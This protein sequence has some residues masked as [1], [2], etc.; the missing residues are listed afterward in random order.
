MHSGRR[1]QRSFYSSHFYTVFGIIGRA[2]DREALVVLDVVARTD[3]RRY[4]ACPP[5]TRTLERGVAET[6]IRRETAWADHR[7]RLVV[8]PVDDVGVVVELE[9]CAVKWTN[10]PKR[11]DV[12]F[13]GR[14]SGNMSF[15]KLLFVVSKQVDGMDSSGVGGA[16][17]LA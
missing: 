9:G 10:V 1:R 7:F 16:G 4:D 12:N 14:S 5:L 15:L 6:F 2:Y 13:F 11:T 8:F 17:V 3:S